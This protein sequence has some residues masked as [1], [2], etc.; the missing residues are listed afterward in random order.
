MFIIIFDLLLHS[1]KQIK[2]K[3]IIYE[4]IRTNFIHIINSF[5]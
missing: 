2:L 1:N 5:H 4:I 3:N